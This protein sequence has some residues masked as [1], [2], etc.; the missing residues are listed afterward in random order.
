MTA[1]ALNFSNH[2]QKRRKNLIKWY[3]R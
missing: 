3:G 1:L 2:H